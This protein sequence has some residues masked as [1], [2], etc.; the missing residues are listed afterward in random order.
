LLVGSDTVGRGMEKQVAKSLPRSDLESAFSV[1]IKILKKE[2]ELGESPPCTKYG[3]CMHGVGPA[4]TMHPLGRRPGRQRPE[5]GA[6]PNPPPA[7]DDH[8]RRSGSCPFLPLQPLS[9]PLAVALSALGFRLMTNSRRHFDI[10]GWIRA[11]TPR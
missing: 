7:H 4:Y 9:P 1:N 6:G 5:C 2:K 10:C 11:K 8:I 3:W